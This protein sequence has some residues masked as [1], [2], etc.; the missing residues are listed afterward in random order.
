M[1]YR[2]IVFDFNGVILW[3]TPWHKEAWFL[4]SK[5]LR[6]TSFSEE[7]WLGLIGRNNNDILQYIFGAPVAPEQSLRLGQRKEELY[8]SIARAYPQDLHLSPGAEELFNWLL[9]KNIPHT[10]ATSSEI[11]NLKFYLDVFNLERWFDRS[12]IIYDD[13]TI[14]CKPN[15]ELYLRATAAIGLLPFECMI[16]EDAASGIEAALKAG[17]GKIIA[18]GPE[19]THERLRALEG[20]GQVLCSLA[21]IRRDDL[22]TGAP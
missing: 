15:P 12:K 19:E 7:E 2:G 20:V 10:I 4:L 13:G 1:Q 18:L 11:T 16:V 3:D 14:P 17:A 9:E 21:E 5:E 6:G 22:Y 8:R